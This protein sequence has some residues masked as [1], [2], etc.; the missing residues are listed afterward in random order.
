MWIHLGDWSTLLRHTKHQ[1]DSMG[2]G[3]PTS[4]PIRPGQ[5]MELGSS[6]ISSKSF[7][8]ILRWPW[9]PTGWKSCGRVCSSTLDLGAD[10][11]VVNHVEPRSYAQNW[12]HR[13][14]IFPTNPPMIALGL[15]RSSYPRSGPTSAS[16]E[17]HLRCLSPPPKLVMREETLDPPSTCVCPPCEPPPRQKGVSHS[18]TIT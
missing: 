11:Y 9:I 15:A 12:G 17:F 16:L 10:F 7:C 13:G 18:P 4:V 14:L 5:K 1:W 8:G 3:I 2:H 6:R